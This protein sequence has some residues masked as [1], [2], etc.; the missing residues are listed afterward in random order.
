MARLRSPEETAAAI[1]GMARVLSREGEIERTAELLAFVANWPATPY[2]IRSRAEKTL[3][4][5]ESPVVAGYPMPPLRSADAPRRYHVAELVG[6]RWTR[7]DHMAGEA[8]HV[9]RDA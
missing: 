2:A 4:E 3:R 1:A 8:S 9:K 7:R 6:G 5:M